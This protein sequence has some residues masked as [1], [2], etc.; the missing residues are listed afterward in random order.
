M[1]VGPTEDDRR[2]SAADIYGR[3]SHPT[4]WN[5]PRK[6]ASVW[7]R[8]GFSVVLAIMIVALLAVAFAVGASTVR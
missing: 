5:L 3:T 7:R 1:T 6:R 4:A 2:V 8:V